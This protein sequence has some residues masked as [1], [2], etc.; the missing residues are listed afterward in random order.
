[1]YTVNLSNIT[2]EQ[3]ELAGGKAANLGELIKAGFPVPQGFAI[4]SAAYGAFMDTNGFTGDFT[5]DTVKAGKMPAPLRESIIQAY[6][7]M[8]ENVCVAVR[9]SATAEDLPDASFAGQ[10]ETYLNLRGT[11]AVIEAVIACFASLWTERAISYRKKTGFDKQ[12]VSLAVVVQEMV[13]GDAAGV[14]FTANPI[15][16]NLN[17]MVINAAYGLGES[18][19]SGLA[20]PDTFIWDTAAQAI[21]KKNLGSKEIAVVYGGEN[22]TVQQ[23]NTDTMRGQFCISDEEVERLADIGKRI[24]QH[25]GCPMDIEWAVKDGKIYILQARGITT[26]SG[27]SAPEQ[28]GFDIKQMMAEM[29]LEYYPEPPY[30]LELTPICAVFNQM[31][32]GMR[33]MG[34]YMEYNP[35]QINDNGEIQFKVEITGEAKPED[36][37]A[38]ETQEPEQTDFIEN[39]NSTRKVFEGVEQKFAEIERQDVSRLPLCA[40][41]QYLRELMECVEKITYTRIQYCLQPNMQNGEYIAGQLK[42]AGLPFNENDLLVDLSYK[43][44]DMNAAVN[45]L[46]QALHA[47][48]DWKRR[49]LQIKP[50]QAE[51]GLAEMSKAFPAFGAMY[52]SLIKNY[53]W[54]STDSH[55]SFSAV[56]WNEN[57]GTLVA[58]L[59]V[60]LAQDGTGAT[61]KKYENLLGQIRA[62]V[63][64][65]ETDSLLQKIEESRAYHQNREES[66]Y[67]FEHC[68]GLCRLLLKEIAAKMGFHAYEDILYL[69]MD[70]VLALDESATE[71]LPETI[72]RRR[73]MQYKNEALWQ[74]MKSLD[75]AAGEKLTGVSGSPGKARGRVCIVHE[76]SEFGKLQPGDIL[77]CKSSDPFWTPL[78]A[79]AKA[80]VTDAGGELSHSAIVAREYGIP[81]VMGCKSATTV[82]TDGQEIIVD[83]DNGVVEVY[84]KGE[85]DYA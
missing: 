51:A 52:T 57:K 44:W 47:N 26:L 56:S 17:E 18:V 4:T 61:P 1:M 76:V 15:N 65:E 11:D 46:A 31:A 59:K 5:M 55:R 67:L 36:P 75:E 84:A 30:P 19:V 40:M 72:A 54:K 81:A 45:A 83:G 68:Y 66:L 9:S 28:G 21:K 3:I 38:E 22:Q 82:L 79:I 23:A 85:N 20:T 63:P 43:T 16:K 70:E 2:K 78:F 71:G 53:G 80:V 42:K 25:Y 24:E 41:Q 7:A 64:P 12:K 35:L 73:K 49:F 69:S 74:S 50:E 8:G 33:D 62:A 13:E 48:P 14:M 39:I 29:L 58:V 10:Q 37:Q 77:V 60:F 6:K 32:D 34:F 27:G